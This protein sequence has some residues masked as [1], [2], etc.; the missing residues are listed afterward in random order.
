MTDTTTTDAQENA[1]DAEAPGE[2]PALEAPKKQRPSFW[3]RPYVER[4]FVP[5]FLP[6]AVVF[7]VVVYIL[8]VSRLF[9]SAHADV[10]VVG[11]IITVAILFGA[12]WL[13]LSNRLRSGSIALITAGFIAVIMAAGAINLGQ[14]EEKEA[15]EAATLKCDL[16]APSTLEF[17]AGPNGALAFDPDDVGSS[18]GLV[19]ISMTDASPAEHTL[20]FDNPDTKF[21][22]IHVA[23]NGDQSEC[24]AFFPEAGDYS[25]YCTIP[26]HRAAGMEGVVRVE[27]EP[28]TLAEAEAAAG[29]GEAPAAGGETPTS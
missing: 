28:I 2:Q 22:E 25:F 16:G 23:G 14:S 17:V 7:G 1:P 19:K 15:N 9:L 13:A 26:G 29:G 24:V 27:G 4:Y 10:V 5:L 20:K 6:I 21:A 18:T 11:T 8:N 12:A 3:D